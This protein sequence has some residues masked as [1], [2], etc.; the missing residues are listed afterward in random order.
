MGILDKENL[1]SDGMMSP[2][3]VIKRSDVT[4]DACIINFSYVI[5]DALIENGY[6]ELVDDTTIIS[7][8]CKYPIYRV[9][10]TNIGVVKTTV[11]APIA[12]TLIEEISYAFDCDKFV[13]FGT[14]GGLDKSIDSGKII[15]PTFAYRDE[16]MSYHYIEPS[17]TIDLPKADVVAR[18]LG[19]LNID[20]VQGGTWTTDAFYRETR[21]KYDKVK[22]LGCIA[23]EMEISACQAVATFRDVDFY[24]MLFRGDNLDSSKW[25]RGFTSELP[26]DTRLQRFF[27]A[28]EVARRVL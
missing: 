23:V 1:M 5:M 20:Y 15:V 11:G 27:I 16:G 2:S 18:I 19:E 6:V 9:K 17:D 7:V 4:L 28:L 8:A 13:L 12:S 26:A 25:E 21:A 24:A 22:A 10:G 3:D 14:C